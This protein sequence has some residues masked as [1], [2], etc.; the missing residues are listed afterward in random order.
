MVLE[1]ESVTAINLFLL[2]TSFSVE[3]PQWWIYKP[4]C[5]N[6]WSVDWSNTSISL[7]FWDPSLKIYTWMALCFDFCIIWRGKKGINWD[8][9]IQN[10]WISFPLL[11]ILCLYKACKVFDY[12][13]QNSFWICSGVFFN[14]KT[15]GHKEP[16]K[17]IHLNIRHTFY[18]KVF[19][20]SGNIGKK[21]S[22]R[23]YNESCSHQWSVAKLSRSSMKKSS[24]FSSPL[25]IWNFKMPGF[26]LFCGWLSFKDC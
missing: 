7:S 16:E 1:T 3:L 6:V 13:R 26:H 2:Q 11:L 15:N 5:L 9:L 12:G 23:N 10:T 4:L 14:L 25:Y 8:S 24:S 21:D 22:Y 17:R 19:K 20:N 18:C